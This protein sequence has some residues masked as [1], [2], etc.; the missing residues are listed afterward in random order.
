MAPIANQLLARKAQ[1]CFEMSTEKV[2]NELTENER[3]RSIFCAQ[4]G[5]YGS[6]PSRSSFAIQALV[7]KHFSWGAYYPEGG[8][9]SIAKCLLKTVAD[10]GGWTQI[11][12]DVDEILIQKGRA[13]GVRLQTGEEITAQK[14][15]SA[16]GI[17]STIQRLMPSEYSQQPWADSIQTLPKSAAHVCLYLG[18]KGDIRKAGCTAANKWFY[19][20]WDNEQEPWS[21]D[22]PDNLGD[23]AILYCSFPSLKD[24]LFDAGPEQR[25]TGEVVTFVPW[26]SFAPWLD[27]RWQKRGGDYADFKK[28]LEAKLLEQF[29]QHVPG[30]RGMVEYAEISTPLSTDNFVRPMHG[31]IYGIEPTPDRFRNHWLRARPPV[32]NLYFSG[33]EL[34][35]VGVIGAMMGGVLGACAASPMRAYSLM[36]KMM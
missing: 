24:P 14:I 33:S 22:Q 27:T 21:I 20:T 5:Y 28:K 2:V 30:L 6:P 29:L 36:K 34:A 25:H 19:N 15:V 9:G 10:A 8:S 13:I 12:A 18:F 1:R 26:E 7:V 4:W 3:L 31:A 35:S 16:V 32:K 23:A 17:Q 11:R